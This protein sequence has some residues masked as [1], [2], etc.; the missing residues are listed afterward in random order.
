MSYQSPAFAH[1]TLGPPSPYSQ[2]PWDS[3]LCLAD[4]AQLGGCQSSPRSGCVSRLLSPGAGL[5]FIVDSLV[6]FSRLNFLS[7]SDCLIPNFVFV[8]STPPRPRYPQT[9]LVCW[10]VRSAHGWGRESSGSSV[11]LLSWEPAFPG[12]CSVSYTVGLTVNLSGKYSPQSLAI[13]HSLCGPSVLAQ[14]CNLP[15]DDS[16]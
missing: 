16:G 7:G 14:G 6:T 9:L 10:M 12:A 8:F 5:V 4:Q 15:K 13:S 2:G 1:L 11:I 3:R